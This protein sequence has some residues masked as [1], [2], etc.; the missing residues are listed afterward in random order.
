M[1]A[2]LENVADMEMSFGAE[3]LDKLLAELDSTEKEWSEGAALFAA[4]GF[5]NDVRKKIL[6]IVILRI[7]DELL[8]KGEK[9]PTEKVLDA[10]SHS[11]K[12]YVEWLDRQVIARASWLA[13]DSRRNA[14][15]LR[16]NR[17]QSLLRVGAL[18][19]V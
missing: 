5:A 17:G 13:L 7:R 16:V 1:T 14:I 10:M 12:Q 4:G 18:R 19:A 11:D 15:L 2:F 8:M 9:A 3:P 6:S